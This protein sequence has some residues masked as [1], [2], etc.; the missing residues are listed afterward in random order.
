MS[1]LTKHRCIAVGDR[2]VSDARRVSELGLSLPEA[3]LTGI[4]VAGVLAPATSGAT[5]TGLQWNSQSAVADDDVVHAESVVT[6]IEQ[7]ETGAVFDRHVRLVDEAGSIREEGNETWR[8]PEPSDVRFDPAVDFCTPD[9]GERLRESLST[10]GGEFTT[11]GAA[12]ELVP[13]GEHQVDPG[14]GYEYLRLTKPLDIIIAHARSAA[15]E[16]QSVS[17]HTLPLT[18]GREARP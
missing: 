5:R 7:S 18:C 3:S 9:W 12:H 2:S 6:R 11:D 13:F 16:W 4:G 17:G 10:A 14:D 1:T 15:R 8:S